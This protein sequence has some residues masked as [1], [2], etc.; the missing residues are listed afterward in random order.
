MNEPIV[1]ISTCSEK[2]SSIGIIRISS[3]KDKLIVKKVIESFLKKKFIFPRL[4]T[5]SKIFINNKE[6]DDGIIIFFPKNKSYTGEDMLEIQ[7]HG[8]IFILKKIFKQLLKIGFKKARR[9]EFTKRAI[10]NKKMNFFDVERLYSLYMLRRNKRGI[11]K[12][13]KKYKKKFFLF[14]RKIFKLKLLIENEINFHEKDELFFLKV[15]NMSKEIIFEISSFLKKKFFLFKKKI[16]ISIIG[17]ENVGKSTLFNILT[18]KKRSITSKYPGTTTNYVKEIIRIKGEKIEMY[19][20][21]G[22]NGKKKMFKNI[23]KKNEKILKRSDIIIKVHNKIMK[24]TTKKKNIINVIN[25]ADNICKKN[26]FKKKNFF[27]SCKFMYGI[28]NLKKKISNIV[29]KKSRKGHSLIGSEIKKVFVSLKK[30]S[31]FIRNK[32]GFFSTEILYK[33]IDNLQKKIANIYNFK[34]KKVSKE[35]FKNFCVGK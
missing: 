22:S 4:A 12:K 8:S 30:I 9:G 13:N 23:K 5:Y 32:S 24:N 26:I 27:I 14:N 34:N 20:T 28:R 17:K 18:N 33:K 35:I 10:E 3:G 6:I 7:T 16:R 19:D 11:L 2:D 15:K 21:A 1:A 25:K 29:K 31:N